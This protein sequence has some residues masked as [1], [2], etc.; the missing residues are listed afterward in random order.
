MKCYLAYHL[1]WERDSNTSSK[2]TNN[3]ASKYREGVRLKK[4]VRY[5]YHLFDEVQGTN[6]MVEI[7]YKA[8]EP[9]LS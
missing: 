3:E 8:W 5:Q 7:S 2:Y 9:W 4:F 6:D 1:S